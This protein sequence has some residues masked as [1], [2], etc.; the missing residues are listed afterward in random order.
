MPASMTIH[1]GL[2]AKNTGCRELG[3]AFLSGHR[4]A[5]N[6]ITQIAGTCDIDALTLLLTELS[7]YIPDVQFA[8]VAENAAWGATVRVELQ[9]SPHMIA[10]WWWATLIQRALMRGTTAQATIL[11]T[12]TESRASNDE[13][14]DGDKTKTI[15]VWRAI[16]SGNFTVVRYM[17]L[18]GNGYS[19]PVQ[20]YA[21]S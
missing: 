9:Y 11:E 16:I 10:F 14:W 12:L 15:A 1:A 7:T 6:I 19:G 21:N 18:S 13:I 4:S 3:A 5:A 8:V 2:Y 17:A 20:A